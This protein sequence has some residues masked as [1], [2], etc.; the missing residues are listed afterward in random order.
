MTGDC[1][2][3][4]SRILQ[5]PQA[6]GR[7]GLIPSCLLASFTPLVMRTTLS[8]RERKVCAGEARLSMVPVAELSRSYE[9][10]THQ[11]GWQAVSNDRN[12]SLTPVLHRSTLTRF[13]LLRCHR[14]GLNCGPG[15]A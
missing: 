3:G 13:S 10:C 5:L 8:K 4:Q 6:D 9:S 12:F 7:I 2:H 1:Q 15:W 11:P 14:R